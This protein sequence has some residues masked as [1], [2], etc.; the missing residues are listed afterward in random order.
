MNL[1]PIARASL[2]DFERA[3]RAGADGGEDCADGSLGQ[4]EP[5]ARVPLAELQRRAGIKFSGITGAVVTS[6]S[7]P[8]TTAPTYELARDVRKVILGL[9]AVLFDRSAKPRPCGLLCKLSAA[10]MLI[11]DV[12]G[13]PLTPFVLAEPIGKEAARLADKISAEVKKAKKAAAAKGMTPQEAEAAF[14]RR[15][16]KL[17]LPTAAE[18][19]K[20]WR[21]IERQAMPLPPSKKAAL[22]SPPPA[23]MPQ[24][25]PV[26][27]E[28]KPQV[29][30]TGVGDLSVP[31]FANRRHPEIAGYRGRPGGDDEERFWNPTMPPCVP[32]DRRPARLF[33]SR[34]AAEAAGAAS[35]VEDLA[36]PPPDD[37]EYGE[38]DHNPMWDFNEDEYEVAC[39]KHR[40]KLR[41]LREA[42]PEAGEEHHTRPCPCGRGALAMWPWVVQTAQ[43]GFCECNMARWELTC[44]RCEWIAAGAPNLAW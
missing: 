34:E 15:H 41:R 14:L 9:P 25:T 20:K 7:G 18:I 36:P 12:L 3:A 35:R 23:A 38:D 21:Q 13:L 27:A 40:Q 43:L 44:W 16:I 4:E 10:G 1:R 2:H 26:A 11:C 6:G 8:A 39:L 37:E 42:F 28:P 17:P 24:S 30:F 22:P 33:N 31:F 19:A 29:D 5:P 32:S